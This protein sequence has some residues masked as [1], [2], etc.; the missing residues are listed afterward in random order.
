MTAATRRRAASRRWRRL[1][2][3]CA[4]E[5]TSLHPGQPA[6]D[7]VA[8]ERDPERAVLGV[9]DRS[10]RTSRRPSADT[11]VATTTACAATRDPFPPCRRGQRHR[12]GPCS[13]WRPRTH[14][15]KPA[16]TAPG[17]RNAATS[18]S[19]SAQIRDTSH[20]EIPDPAPIACTRSS[21]FRTLV[22]VHVGL[23]HH[24]EQ[25]LV[26]PAAPLQQRRE[27]RPGPQLRDRHLH[28]PGRGGHQPSPIPVALSR[29]RRSAHA[30]PRRSAP[31]PPRRS[32]P[33][34][35]LHR[36]PDHIIGIGDLQR[37]QH[38]Q[39]GRLSQG[40]RVSLLRKDP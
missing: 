23:H 19:R 28:V 3:V 7:Q 15:G 13:S 2:P 30:G 24:R 35:R 38:L 20:L 12:S 17:R 10:P 11:P 40:H 32:A 8:Q 16:R 22:P 36:R 25:R 29:A 6:G 26:D 21:T 18:S 4:S 33:A 27:E 9:A 5:M 31:S 1:S 39:Q 34:N 14:T 37:L